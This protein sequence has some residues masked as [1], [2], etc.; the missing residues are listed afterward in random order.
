MALSDTKLRSINGK[1]YSGTAEVT[2]GDGLSARITPTG[3]IT[4]QFRYRWNG[5]P[6]RLNVGRYPSTSLKDARV[7]VGEMRA[8]YM[9]G[10]NPKNY[11]TRSDGELTLKECLEQW[12]DKYVTDLKPN[13]QTLYRSVVYNTM[14]T[15]FEDAPVANIPVS[16]WVRFFDKQESLN[17]KKARV[18][19]LQLR[20]VINW[21]ISRQLIP[22]CELLKLSV[23]NIGKKPDIGSRVLTYSEL[24]KVWLAL[25]NNKIVSSNKLLHQ[26]LLLWGARLSEL[27]LA[28]AIEFNMG[29]LI[30][31]TPGEHSKMGNVIR[32]PIFDQVKPYVERLLN[33]GNYILFPGQELDK[34]IDRS[35][36]N[37]YMKKL[38]DKID[39]PEWRTH[40]FRRSLVTNLSGEGVM[41]HVTEKMLGHEL[42][43]VMAVYNKHDWLPE[44]KEAY[45]L[46][47]DKIFWHV[48]QLG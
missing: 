3:T 17:K 40:D 18:L 48:K 45:E 46:Y 34:A 30:W 22:S 33:N 25:E 21:C 10:V 31:T 13:T 26:L 36:A 28:T 24:A 44:Q 8:L 23:K 19:L 35:S 11:F 41:P 1:P 15:Q 12:W 20:S 47:A 38:R 27:R 14:Y 37:L 29:D 4:F 7:I 32:R 42:G 9:K 16:A 5:K 43:G 2:D 39:I 6:V